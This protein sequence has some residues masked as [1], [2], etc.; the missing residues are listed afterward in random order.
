M[1][2]LIWQSP[3][4]FTLPAA[5]GP[6]GS[7]GTIGHWLFNRWLLPFEVASVLLLARHP[8]RR[9]PDEAEALVMA[10][11]ALLSFAGFLP[12][13]TAVPPQKTALLAA[14]LFAIGIVGVTCRRNILIMLL[15]VEIM[16]NAANLMLVTFCKV[17]GDLDRA[18]LRLLRDDRGRR[19]GGGRAR[20]RRSPST[21]CAGPRTSTRW[22]TCARSTT[23][24]S[25]TLSSRACRSTT[26]T[27][28]TT[29]GPRRRDGRRGAGA[30][31]RSGR[32]RRAGHV[33]LAPRSR[34]SRPAPATTRS[35]RA[36]GCSG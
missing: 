34:C 3:E 8:R 30:R 5:G 6:D 22:A 18:G 28:T 4:M 1:V 7:A 9:D 23:G 14:V 29:T 35:S 26:T 36:T 2:G 33:S 10:S 19:R 21:A 17:H 24:R 25:P 12:L 32:A 27:T 13:A 31:A 20:H 15:S 11:S 16:L